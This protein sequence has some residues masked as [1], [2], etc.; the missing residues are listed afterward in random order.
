MVVLTGE[1][2]QKNPDLPEAEQA[3]LAKV[4]WGMHEDVAKLSTRG[5]HRLVADTG[6][7]IPSQNPKAVIDAVVGVVGQARKS[8]K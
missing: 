6:H 8:V 3:S 7:M 4:W 1:N 5:E 2:T